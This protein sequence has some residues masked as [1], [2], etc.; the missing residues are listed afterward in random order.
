MK[1]T[2]LMQE[3]GIM[4]E[5]IPVI[6]NIDIAILEAIQDG[7]DLYMGNW[8]GYTGNWCGTTHCSGGWAIHIAGEAGKELQDCLREGDAAQLIY[9]VS[10][11][12]Q[13]A[14]D[15][16]CDEEEA[17]DD[18]KRCAAAQQIWTKVNRSPTP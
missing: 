6:P 4:P 8:H 11:P 1:Q 13:P 12:G 3:H 17:M 14:P 5:E 10:R 9:E 2:S 18:I 7:G 16:Y 15:F